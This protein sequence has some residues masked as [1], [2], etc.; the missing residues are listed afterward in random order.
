MKKLILAFSLL[1]AFSTQAGLPPPSN[2]AFDM[3]SW[4]G[5][6]SIAPSKNAI[7]DIYDWNQRIDY[8]DDFISASTSGVMGWTAVQSGTAAVVSTGGTG[9][10][11]NPGLLRLETGTDT[12]GRASINSG[13]SALL[14]GTGTD[15][16]ECNYVTGVASDGTDTYTIRIGFLDTITGDSVDGAYFLYDSTVSANWITKTCSNSSCTT[17]TS[18]S[19]VGINAYRRM[20]IVA[21]STSVLFYNNGTLIRTETST[22]PSTSSRVFGFGAVMIK[23][24]GTTNRILSLDWC[25]YTK[26]WAT[27]RT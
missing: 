25:H 15:T 16:F 8:H 10:N 3:S 9:T 11:A 19:A 21:T 26:T 17:T 22:I 18:S 4:D 12:T 24:A 2:T 1:L 23:S 20:K 14:F 13:T 5:V 7:R 27:P 6:I